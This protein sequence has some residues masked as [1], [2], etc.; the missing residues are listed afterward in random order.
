MIM[1]IIMSRQN[2]LRKK[3]VPPLKNLGKDS[4]AKEIQKK[5]WQQIITRRKNN[6]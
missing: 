1:M 3:R 2:R 5:N 6:L 4:E